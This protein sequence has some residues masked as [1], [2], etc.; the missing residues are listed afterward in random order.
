MRKLSVRRTVQ[1]LAVALVAAA[2]L[3]AMPVAAQKPVTLADLENTA[4]AEPVQLGDWKV[5]PNIVD[6]HL[7]MPLEAAVARLKAQY[8]KAQRFQAWPT[9]PLLLDTP[10]KQFTSGLTIQSSNGPLYQDDINVTVTHPPHAQVV[11][12]VMRHLA[13]QYQP[14]NRATLL[15]ALRE[16]YGKEMVATMGGGGNN[17]VATNDRSIVELHWL[18]DEQGRRVSPAG[19]RGP[20]DGYNFNRCR[21][22]LL[23]PGQHLDERSVKE[24]ES[25]PHCIAYVGVYANIDRGTDAEIITSFRLEMVNIPLFLRASKATLAWRAAEMEKLRQQ[26]TER[27]KRVKPKL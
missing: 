2:G 18:F 11:W 3:A 27:S 14:V 16:K 20:E 13:N 6:V 12:N 4:R 24:I 25:M 1:L 7:H 5:M 23:S 17:A 26:E 22:N 15:A 9:S 10:Q 19:A 8:P 21:T